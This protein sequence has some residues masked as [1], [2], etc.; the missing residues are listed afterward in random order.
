MDEM[1]KLNSDDILSFHFKIKLVLS[2]WLFLKKK[3]SSEFENVVT[4]SLL[5]E[6]KSYTWRMKMHI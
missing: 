5:F 2:S 1:P 6:Q 3:K 4:Q